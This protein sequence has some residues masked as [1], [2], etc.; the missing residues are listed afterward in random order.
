MGKP[1]ISIAIPTYNEEK[2]IKECLDSILRQKY[3]ESKLEVFVVDGGSLDKTIEIAK[4]YPVTIIP[5]PEKDAQRG[6]MLALKKATGDYYI[7]LDGDSFLKGTNWFT[8]ML[9]PL[10]EDT[11]IIASFSRYYSRKS[12]HWL[13]RFLY[14]DP[15]GRDPIYEFFSPAIEKSF[16]QKRAGYYL[17]EFNKDLIPPEGRC[18][19]RVSILKKSLIYKR[20]KFMELD[21]LAILVSEGKTRFA[22]V[23]SAGFYHN[24]ILG[25]KSLIRKRFR[26]INKNYLHQEEGRYYTWFNLRSPR[27]LLKV[28]IWIVYANTLVFGF[29]RGIYKSIK[30]KD[31]VCLIEPVLNIIETDII[32]FGFA[33]YFFA[34]RK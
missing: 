3:P 9:K 28:L 25:F 12:D 32:I 21:N 29:L 18:L 1:K 2:N 24:F 15:I 26:N 19:Y 14:Y 30:Y 34:K 11:S 13:T 27:G 4:V 7:Y 20:H 17:C 16:K 8:K 31:P 22:Y 23:P 6:K 10:L 33:W 5:N